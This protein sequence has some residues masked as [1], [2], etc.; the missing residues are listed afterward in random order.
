MTDGSHF[1]VWRPDGAMVTARTIHVG[2]GSAEDEIP[3]RIAY[4]NPGDIT[5][6]EPIPDNGRKR[7]SRRRSK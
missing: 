1:D 3:E 5:R 6:I 4:C 2:V 7:G